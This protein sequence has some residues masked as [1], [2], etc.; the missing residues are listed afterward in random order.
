MR[1]ASREHGLNFQQLALENDQYDVDSSKLAFFL[2]LSSDI[3]YSKRQHVYDFSKHEI[4]KE[5]LVKDDLLEH[6]KSLIRLAFSMFC[7]Y[8]DGNIPKPDYMEGLDD[9]ARSLI[10][11]AMI[12]QNDSKYLY[13]AI[14]ETK[15]TL[16]DK[17]ITKL[18]TMIEL[19][20]IIQN[21]A[22][23]GRFYC[24]RWGGTDFWKTP[25]ELG[26]DEPYKKFQSVDNSTG[27]AWYKEFHTY[28]EME[29]WHFGVSK[30]EQTQVEED[31]NEED[32]EL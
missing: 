1:F 11:D 26:G 19:S 16:V 27:H 8:D 3:I 2:I 4:I 10:Y 31:E 21:K 28:K 6:D 20:D 22:P 24:R 23:I 7:D 25:D 32:H 18:N 5:C 12:V 9:N 17:T 29:E 14:A 15:I 30:D 13:Q